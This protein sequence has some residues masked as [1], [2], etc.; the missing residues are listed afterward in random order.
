MEEQFFMIYVEGESSPTYKHTT[1]SSAITEAKRLTEQLNK[2]A[3]ILTAVCKVE[4]V[5]F[6]ITELKPINEDT[7][8]F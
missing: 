2:P 5:K 8:P 4:K 1:Y 7:L 6:N 3:F